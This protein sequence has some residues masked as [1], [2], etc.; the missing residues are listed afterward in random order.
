[1]ICVYK[2]FSELYCHVDTLVLVMSK[3]IA[4]RG[5]DR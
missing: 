1:M 4:R 2:K 5:R 3:V